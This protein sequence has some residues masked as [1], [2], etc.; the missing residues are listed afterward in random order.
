M[1]LDQDKLSKNEWQNIEIPLDNSEIDIIKLI[2]KGFNDVNIKINNNLSFLTFLKLENN[3]LINQY[4]FVKYIEPDI[5]NIYK[6][7][8]R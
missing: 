2:I 6:K 1:N 4:I 8:T 3:D 7:N 5:I